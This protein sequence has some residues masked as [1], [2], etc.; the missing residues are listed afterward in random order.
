MIPPKS[1]TQISKQQACVNSFYDSRLGKVIEFGSVL[2]MLPGWGPNPGK[3][4]AENIVLTGGKL[5]ALKGLSKVAGNQVIPSVVTGVGVSV[6]SPL[7]RLVS[8]AAGKILGFAEGAGPIGVGGAT[9]ADIMAHGTCAM[10]ADP[11]L[12][13]AALQSVP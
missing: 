6:A 8:A 3:S 5:I 11:S 10:Q 13:D 9:V 7:E 2:S 12:A 4:A 1:G